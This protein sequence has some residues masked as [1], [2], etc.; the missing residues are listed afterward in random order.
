MTSQAAPNVSPAA[1]ITLRYW[2]SLRAAAG[3]DTDV[4]HVEGPVTLADLCSR[5]RGLH[6]EARFAQVLST[7]SVLVGERPVA[8]EEP[9]AVRVPPG[10]T[11][12]FLPPF[13]GG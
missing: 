2:A 10:E 3:V 1:Q 5:A 7:C 13:A 6:A 9:T 8:S 12:E 4:V 11:V